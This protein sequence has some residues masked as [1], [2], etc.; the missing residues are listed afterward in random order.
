MLL[1]GMLDVEAGK[2]WDPRG[3]GGRVRGDEGG[4]GVDDGSVRGKG[5][6]GALG[7]RE[8]WRGLRKGTG[9]GRGRNGSGGA[10]AAPRGSSSGD[11]SVSMT[12]ARAGPSRQSKRT[13]TAVESAVVSR[14]KLPTRRPSLA[15]IFGLGQKSPKQD[16][17]SKPGTDESSDWDAAADVDGPVRT[18]RGTKRVKSNESLG[19]ATTVRVR[20]RRDASSSPEKQV[21]TQKQKSP[22]Q[23]PRSPRLFISFSDGPTSG[24]SSASPPTAGKRRAASRAHLALKPENIRLL[25]GH[26]RDVS[27]RLNEC[28]GEVRGMMGGISV[29][30]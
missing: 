22:L 7:L 23:A 14:R 10:E 1:R 27:V 30:A 24:P 3:V 5:R 26:A 25:L 11:S 29:V 4:T 9:S 28:I 6:G 20:K 15:G 12:D 2:G 16:A 13:V 18:I 8:F 17:T 21:R 19:A